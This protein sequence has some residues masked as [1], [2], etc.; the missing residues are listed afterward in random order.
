ML[1]ITIYV[2][3]AFD[4]DLILLQVKIGVLAP[5]DKEQNSDENATRIVQKCQKLTKVIAF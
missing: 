5:L 2:T 3:Q 1:N 4:R